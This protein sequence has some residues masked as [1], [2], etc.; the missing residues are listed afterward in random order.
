M[1]AAGVMPPPRTLLPHLAPRWH[2]QEIEA[3]LVRLYNLDGSAGREGDAG[4]KAAAL[5]ALVAF[6]PDARPASGR[7]PALP[8]G[9]ART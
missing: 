6:D 8:S 9:R 7:R 4:G 2:R 3:V 1:V 5:A